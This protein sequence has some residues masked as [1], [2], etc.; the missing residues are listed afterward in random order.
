[1]LEAKIDDEGVEDASHWLVVDG[2]AFLI[3]TAQIS[4]VSSS[5]RISRAVIV[6]ESNESR[7]SRLLQ[8]QNH[9]ND[10]L[11]LSF[12]CW[13]SREAISCHRPGVAAISVIHRCKVA[14]NGTPQS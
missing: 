13:E 7:E 3:N 2:R 8:S 10:E 12:G 9:T 1:M 5:K 14:V 4:H 11:Q 6:S